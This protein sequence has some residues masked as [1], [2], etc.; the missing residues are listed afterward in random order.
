MFNSKTPV[1]A[2]STRL[3]ARLSYP[4]PSL[5][6]LLPPPFHGLSISLASFATSGYRINPKMWSLRSTLMRERVVFSFWI[7]IA[8]LGLV[9]PVPS[10]HFVNSFHDFRFLQHSIMNRCFQF[11][12]LSW[13]TFCLLRFPALV[14][15]AAWT[16][17]I[18]YLWSKIA[19]RLSVYREYWNLVI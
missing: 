6:F 8:P 19:N 5:V 14:H 10:V 16:G 1:T 12:F 3:T 11:P 18:N 4:A 9:H 15:K 17:L 7:W 13:R 2:S